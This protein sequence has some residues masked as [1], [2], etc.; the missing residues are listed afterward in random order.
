MKKVPSRANGIGTFSFLGDFE[1][2]KQPTGSLPDLHLHFA[3]EREG[4]TEKDV[5]LF[6]VLQFRLE[7]Q[8][9]RLASQPA[10]MFGIEGDTRGVMP[11]LQLHQIVTGKLLRGQPIPR[12]LI[13]APGFRLIVFVKRKIDS[14]YG[15]Q[16]YARRLTIVELA[17]EP[18]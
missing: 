2:E 13:H 16:T 11:D 7:S 3:L 9:L 8:D 17:F 14:P 10:W 15:W 18:A 12:F 1:T 6:D 5:R 4:R